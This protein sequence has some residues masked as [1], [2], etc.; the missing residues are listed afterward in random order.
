[1]GAQAAS[2]T[3]LF[4][5]VSD[6]TR[7]YESLGDEG[8]RR[9]LL[10]C[11]DLMNQVIEQSR[12][13]VVDRIGD[14]LMCTF[15]GP[16]VAG[17]ASCELH[18]AIEAANA[19]LPA[20][21]GIR[22]GFHHGPLV[23][24]GERI[25][26]DTIHVAKRV[27]SLAKPQQTLTTGQAKDLI[28]LT[29]QLVTRFVDRTHL[30]GKAEPFELFEIVWD[31]G[32]ATLAE[33]RSGNTATRRQRQRELV[34][35]YGDQTYR[36][37]SK[38]PTLTIGR[39]SRVDVVIDHARVSRFHARIEFRKGV[40]VLVE[41]STN[42]SHVVEHEGE[43]RFVRRDECALTGKGSIILGPEGVQRNLPSLAYEVRGSDE[44][45]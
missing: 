37:D 15:P 24:D 33:A 30:K 3:V 35:A 5:D 36:L 39:D 6:S 20:A 42:G 17:W 23:L 18:R 25:F 22:I 40:F 34:L 41:Q 44:A 19:D 27:V 13:T 2:R 4:A 32:A 28:P 29:E 43:Q 31:T 9:L 16:S 1:M 21:V 11:L 14:E 45:D 10:G 38:R 7:L 12:G 8:G 26:G